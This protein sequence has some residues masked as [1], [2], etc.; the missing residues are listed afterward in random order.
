MKRIIFLLIGILMLS[1][2]CQDEFIETD[3]SQECST[4]SAKVEKIKTFHIKGHIEAIPNFDL[5]PISCVP[6]EYD[7]ILPASGWVSGHENIVGKFVQEESFYEKD[8][9]E[10]SITPE[11]PVVY[12]HANVEITRSNGDKVFVENHT[13][14]NVETG[15]ISGYNELIGGTGRFEGAVGH[16]DMLNA[17]MD[18]ETGI[19]SWDEDGYITLVLK[20]KKAKEL[21]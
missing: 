21:L 13:W 5:P 2:A 4:K 10:I 9:C 6:I 20:D 1:V 18:P 7:I 14:I 8:L 15:D 19:A 3:N 12:S 17:V 16:A 11:G